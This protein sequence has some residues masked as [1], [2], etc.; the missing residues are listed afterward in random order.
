MGAYHAHSFCHESSTGTSTGTGTG[1]STGTGTGTSTGT[2]TSIIS[3][4]VR[5]A[6]GT[7][8]QLS[9]STARVQWW[10]RG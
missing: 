2:S 6:T 9:S 4:S 5:K 8:H 1:T 10:S 7:A 3:I